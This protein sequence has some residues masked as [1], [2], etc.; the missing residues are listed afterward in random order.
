MG[1]AD[2]VDKTFDAVT[3]GDAFDDIK[4]FFE[5]A[6]D[7]VSDFFTSGDFKN[8]LGEGI[9]LG[10]D[11]ADGFITHGGAATTTVIEGLVK[12]GGE[13]GQSSL[14][15][16]GNVLGAAGEGFG[17]AFD[18]LA[19]F[20]GIPTP[21]Q[22]AGGMMNMVM[23]GAVILVLVLVM[24]NRGGGGGGSAPPQIVMLPSGQVANIAG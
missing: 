23:I 10:V 14:E 20:L 4:D 18:G 12:G 17:G 9:D 24:S 13:L 8:L 19:N 6:A 16:G 2:W 11:I 5:D 21:G 22:A 7:D 1:F 3:S 15:V